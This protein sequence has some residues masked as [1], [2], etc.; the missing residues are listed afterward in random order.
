MSKQLR[1]H[2]SFIPGLRPGPRTAEYLETVMTR[3]TF[4]GAAF[5]A[6]IALIPTVVNKSLHITYSARECV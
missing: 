5:L 6:V 4:V 1:D 2:G 3:I